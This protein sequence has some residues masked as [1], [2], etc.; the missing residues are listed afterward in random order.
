MIP[1][2]EHHH[3]AL[4]DLCRRYHVVRLEVFG[5]AAEADADAEARDVDFLVEFA[6]EQDLGPWMQQYFDLRD[7]LAALLGR[8]IDLVMPSS[9]HNP[10]FVREVN[11][12]RRPLYAA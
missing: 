11:R 10:Y 3:D 8:P 6:P 12:T 1:L 9:M 5:S 7:E 4:H 2:L